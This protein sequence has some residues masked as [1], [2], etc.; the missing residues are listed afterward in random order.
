[1]LLTLRAVTIATGM[2]DAVVPPTALALREALSV[3]SAAAVLDGADDRAGCGGEVGR[4]LQVCWRNGVQDSA[5][6]GHGRRPCLRA[7]RRS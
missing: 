6:G 1:M 2:L 7:L 3:V 5:V 4:A